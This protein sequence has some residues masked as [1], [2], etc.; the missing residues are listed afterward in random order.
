M[1]PESEYKLSYPPFLE[2]GASCSGGRTRPSR[3]NYRGSARR[4]IFPG[5][6]RLAV[7]FP[8]AGAAAA[9]VASFTA[10]VLIA[11]A[12]LP[13]IPPSHFLPLLAPLGL[14]PAAAS[15]TVSASSAG[16]AALPA[17][18]G[19]P[20]AAARL[21]AAGVAG[22]PGSLP[23]LRAAGSAARRP[24]VGHFRLANRQV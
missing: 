1:L 7:V 8:A 10:A 2:G 4:R 15:P 21:A 5:V 20:T 19:P 6:L 24:A 14:L 12:I 18:V 16:A 17:A 23:A 13:V 11:S 3:G 22:A 9:V